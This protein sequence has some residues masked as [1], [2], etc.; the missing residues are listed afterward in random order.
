MISS[1]NHRH[2]VSP[3]SSETQAFED[4]RRT[5]EEENKVFFIVIVKSGDGDR[6]RF[7][8][9]FCHRVVLRVPGTRG[10]SSD[11]AIFLKEKEVWT[12]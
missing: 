4:E 10:S 9:P 8:V 1:D 6:R 11:W 2:I 3:L 7:D 5:E 12:V